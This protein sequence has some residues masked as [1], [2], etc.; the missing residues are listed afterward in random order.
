MWY[1]ILMTKPDSFAE[2]FPHMAAALE[3]AKV[4]QPGNELQEQAA[5]D[6]TRLAFEMEVRSAFPETSYQPPLPEVSSFEARRHTLLVDFKDGHNMVTQRNTG[7][8]S[9][10]DAI[11]TFTLR[12]GDHDVAKYQSPYQYPRNTDLRNG[13]VLMETDYTPTRVAEY[14]TSADSHIRRLVVEAGGLAALRAQNE[15]ACD[16]FILLSHGYKDMMDVL[17][18][19]AELHTS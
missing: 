4:V 7:G 19:R 1:F 6:I 8:W 10:T 16:A 17:E 12:D 11:E 18:G 9:P 14:W 13:F 3:A 2:K 5:A 15:P